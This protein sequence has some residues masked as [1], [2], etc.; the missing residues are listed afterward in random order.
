M[1][2]NHSRDFVVLRIVSTCFVFLGL[3]IGEHT[4]TVKL[5]ILAVTAGG[6]IYVALVDMVSL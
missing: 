5:W 1:S 3:L 6:F 4:S 2:R